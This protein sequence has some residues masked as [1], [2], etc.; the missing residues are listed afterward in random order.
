MEVAPG[1][2]L[3]VLA[4]GQDPVAA[5]TGHEAH[6]DRAAALVAELEEGDPA[7]EPRCLP[8]VADPPRAPGPSCCPRRSR[9]PPHRWPLPRGH[10]S[11]TGLLT[12]GGARSATGV[13]APGPHGWRGHGVTDPRAPRHGAHVRL[14]VPGAPGLCLRRKTSPQ[15]DAPPGLSPLITPLHPPG[16][17]GR[18]LPGHPQG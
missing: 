17:T 18:Q 12:T 1:L 15:V 16:I 8:S 4:A 7:R 5:G 11:S 10:T 2:G 3:A 13:L 14:G 9:H 6:P